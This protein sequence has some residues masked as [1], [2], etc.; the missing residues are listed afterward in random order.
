M[1][2]LTERQGLIMRT[3][4]A[5]VLIPL[6]LGF[7]V[8]GWGGI[9]AVSAAPSEHEV[10][11]TS[12]NDTL[13]GSL[14]LPDMQPGQ[15]V[16]AA[17]IISGSGP[18]DR[19]GNSALLNGKI[20]SNRNFAQTL[21]NQG[22]ASLRYDKLGT[23]KTGLASHADHPADIGFNLFVD[24]AQAA[25]GYLRSR[26]EIDPQRVM[27]L[28]HSEGGMIALIV[29][30]QLKGTPDQPAALTL[31]APLGSPYLETIRR[32]LTDQY[33][34]GQ[35]AGQIPQTD[36]DAAIAELNA[37]I[38]SLVETQH[39][40]ATIATP[41]LQQIFNPYNEEFLAQV[42]PY[43][44]MQLAAALPPTLPALI[45]HGTKDVQVTSDDV[46]NVMHGFQMAGNTRAAL[47]ELANVDH[48]FKE[49]P[50]DPDPANEYTNPALPFSHEAVDRLNAFVAGSILAA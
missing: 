1:K 2:G 12:G 25:Y 4:T 11:F 3:R 24:E 14:L 36:A 44:P 6:V 33:R 20:D 21:A 16:P 8:G 17:V 15:K 7:L 46:N 35:A 18:T 5:M 10:Q 31:A 13:Y 23:G 29:A 43:D 41:A 32:Q 42:A 45:L 38:K 50:G 39:L 26:P 40:P 19:D 34:A 30:N 47:F 37:I 22:I 28:G 9:I 48:V 49:V 27:I